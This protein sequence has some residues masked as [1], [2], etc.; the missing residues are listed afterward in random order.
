M[1]YQHPTTAFNMILRKKKSRYIISVLLLSSVL[2][3]N[4]CKK[5]TSTIPNT[6]VDL[7]VYLS[8][9]IYANLNSVG[10][11][12]YLTNVGVKGIILYRKSTSDFVAYERSCPYDPNATNAKI[13]V[14]ASNVI[15]VDHNCGSKFNLVD[16]S[17]LSG[18][19]ARQMK[20]YVADYDGAQTVH[21]HN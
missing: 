21:I 17:I 3:L 19:A 20:T 10:N 18:P 6:Y 4:Q 15:G 5:D 13:E 9:P 14:D 1:N 11:W 12:S 16:N 2:S 8:Q 7:Y